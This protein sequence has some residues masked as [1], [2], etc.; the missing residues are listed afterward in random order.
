MTLPVQFSTAY[1]VFS[2]VRLNSQ[3]IFN[4]FNQTVYVKRL[5]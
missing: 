1:T 4:N 5:W 2:T 3:L